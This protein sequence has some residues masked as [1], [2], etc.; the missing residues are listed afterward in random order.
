MVASRDSFTIERLIAHERKPPLSRNLREFGADACHGHSRGQVPELQC[1]T[2]SVSGERLMPLL[3][4]VPSA[5]GPF[6]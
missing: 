5:G 3:S 6:A 4:R 1:L 2:P